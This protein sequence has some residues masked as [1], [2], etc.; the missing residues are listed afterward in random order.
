MAQ[1]RKPPCYQEYAATMLANRRFRYMTLAERG[2]LYNLRL[3]CWENKEVPA[4]S[5]ELAKYLG[6]EET[7]ISKALTVNVKSFFNE[8]NSLF[9][10]PELE[11]YRRHLE[12]IKLKQSKGGKKGAAIT[13]SKTNN[14]EKDSN[15][16]NPRVPRRVSRESVVKIST[17]KQSQNQSL[18][19]G[20]IDPWISEYDNA[21]KV[22]DNEYLRMK[23]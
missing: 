21:L 20:D 15:S 22:V 18:E 5:S 7:E 2:L 11:D 10:C 14:S 4:N 6:I 8:S 12:E 13:N 17:K 3:E 1:N 9:N 19:S 16:S 23:G